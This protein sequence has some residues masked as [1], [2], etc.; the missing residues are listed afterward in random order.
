VVEKKPKIKTQEKAK[1]KH[2][3]S[4]KT[5][6][7]QFK[8]ANINEHILAIIVLKKKAPPMPSIYSA[9]SVMQR[10][11]LLMKKINLSAPS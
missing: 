4:K 8:K 3:M 7:R 10:R 11:E 5:R 9:T 1:F 6:E 2:K